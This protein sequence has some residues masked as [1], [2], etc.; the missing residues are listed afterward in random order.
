MMT[1]Q[2]NVSI[3]S[4]P[5]AA[6]D[7]RALS[8]AWYSALHLAHDS[9]PATTAR[10]L[11]AAPLVAT[12]LNH[13]TPAQKA[14]RTPGAATESRSARETPSKPRAPQSLAADR[15]A[16]RTQLARKI[17]RA[18]LNPRTQVKRATFAIGSGGA[19]V[20]VVLQSN[21]A[22]VRLVAFCPPR[23]RD[24]VARALEQARYALAARGIAMDL[25]TGRALCS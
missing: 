13:E 22:R 18:F 2:L 4:A 1:Q 7:R 19:R 8:Q 12:P 17:E 14:L 9:K 6:I 10:K 25:E 15:R 5:L 16:P 23:V 24:S 11:D 3:L 21:G 20:H